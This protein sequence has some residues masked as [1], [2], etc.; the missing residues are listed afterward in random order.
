MTGGLHGVERNVVDRV[1][2]ELYKTVAK[3][4]SLFAT[5]EMPN[6][7]SEVHFTIIQTAFSARVR[8][9]LLNSSFT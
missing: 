7:I 2:Y 4:Y 6:Y 8:E 1:I 5:R 3:Q 9:K